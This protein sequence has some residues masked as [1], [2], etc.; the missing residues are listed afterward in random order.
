MNNIQTPYAIAHYFDL[1][2]VVAKTANADL[3]LATDKSSGKPLVIWVARTLFKPASPEIGNFLERIKTIDEIEPPISDIQ[4]YGVDS[5]GRSFLVFPSLSGNK[6]ERKV[7]DPIEAERRFIG[8]LSSVAKLHSAGLCSGD[9]T[10]E[11][12]WMDRNGSVLYTGLIGLNKFEA[13]QDFPAEFISLIAPELR[14]SIINYEKLSAASDVYSLG[15][16]ATQI[17]DIPMPDIGGSFD[18]TQSGVGK[19]AW[20]VSVLEKCLSND[21]GQRYTDANHILSDIQKTKLAAKSLPSVKNT[22]RNYENLGK[23]LEVKESDPISLVKY[24]LFGISILFLGLGVYFAIAQFSKKERLADKIAN[25]GNGELAESVNTIESNSASEHEIESEINKL[26]TSADPL[27]HQYLVEQALQSES[28]KIRYLS[29]RAIL[30]RAKKADLITTSDQVYKFLERSTINPRLDLIE[31]SLKLLDGSLK[32]GEQIKY[33]DRIKTL[34][35]DL[36]RRLAIAIGIDQNKLDTFADKIRS[37]LPGTK[38]HGLVASILGDRELTQIFSEELE[39]L[40]EK[41]ST[42]D[43][44]WVLSVS[45]ERG[46]ATLPKLVKLALKNNLVKGLDSEYYK[47]IVK[48]QGLN[49]V[50]AGKLAKAANQDLAVDDIQQISKWYSG[51]SEVAMLLLLLDPKQTLKGEIFENYLGRSPKIEPSASLAAWVN[52]KY[53]NDRLKFIPLIPLLGLREFLNDQSLDAGFDKIKDII[54]KP[55]VVTALLELKNQR[56]LVKFLKSYPQVLSISDKIELLT[57]SDSEIRILT[58]RSIDT[59]DVGALK[60]IG[61]RFLDETDEAVKEEYR[62]HFWTLANR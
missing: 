42:D 34:D 6:L 23:P 48:N 4:F 58:I 27:A 32:V 7:K 46:E 31:L 19:P 22:T 53:K 30:D 26:I 14:G 52:T 47:L 11:S 10:T 57:N 3:Y 54:G 35:K 2:E 25:L 8:C 55:D 9:I 39:R 21:P 50:V 49:P 17:F 29:Q 60:I 43:L 45:A 18:A 1:K 28:K 41:M 37:V 12:F 38:E 59:N 36:F 51:D 5:E 33:L 24:I 61:D 40:I 20:L 62:K 13:M 16:V 44:K 15:C 56:I